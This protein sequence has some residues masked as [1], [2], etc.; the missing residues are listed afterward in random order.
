MVTVKRANVVLTVDNDEVEKY[1]EK[2][3]SIIDE[4]GNVLK[5][6]VPTEVGALQKALQDKEVEI[7]ALKEEIERLRSQNTVYA[8]ALNNPDEPKPEKKQYKQYKKKSVEE[9]Q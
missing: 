8:M 2:G 5:A 6:S 1:F 3:F 4:F 9:E 7:A